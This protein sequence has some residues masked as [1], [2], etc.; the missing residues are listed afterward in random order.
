MSGGSGCRRYTSSPRACWQAAARLLASTELPGALRWGL[1]LAGVE[2]SHCLG[3]LLQRP[4]PQ[5]SG[6]PPTLRNAVL[7]APFVM[8]RGKS[9]AR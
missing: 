2:Q 4:H 6:N 3:S 9:G 7:E 8:F 1:W 5:T